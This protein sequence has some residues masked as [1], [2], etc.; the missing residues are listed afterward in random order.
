[1]HLTGPDLKVETVDR[2]HPAKAQRDLLQCQSA[3]I[4]RGAKQPLEQVGPRNDR[5]VAF[6][7]ATVLEIKQFGN[8]AGDHKHDDEQQ[9]RI[10]EGRPSDQG[11]REFR[12][13]SQE[14]RAEQRAENRAASTDQDSDEK[15]HRQ[16]QRERVGRDVGLQGGE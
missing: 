9:R 14:N 8:S 4:G 10:K 7:R 3:G 2:L 13:H 6:K 11:R 5:A 16:V 15:Q 1:M 12:Q